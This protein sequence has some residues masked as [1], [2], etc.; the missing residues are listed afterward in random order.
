MAIDFF[1][2]AITS[3]RF[4]G[5]SR[6]FYNYSTGVLRGLYLLISTTP[7]MSRYTDE[8]KIH[9]IESLVVYFVPR[10]K[11]NY[12]RNAMNEIVYSSF[13]EFNSTFVDL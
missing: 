9:D 5:K 8:S 4:D 13:I 2:L 7:F 1:F 11:I 3:A 12:Q 10:R 6:E